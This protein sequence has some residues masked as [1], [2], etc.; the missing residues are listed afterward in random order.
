MTLIAGFWCDGA[1]VLCADSQ[2]TRGSL[3]NETNKLLIHGDDV[4][5]SL[6][7]GGAGSGE[8]TD[9]FKLRVAGALVGTQKSGEE[10]I[11]R[12]LEAQLVAFH[13]SDVYERFPGT[14]EEKTIVGLI[15]VRSALQEVFLYHYWTTVIKPVKTYE[16]AGEDYA[17]IKRMGERRFRAGMSVRQATLLGIELI[18][19]GKEISP[20]IGGQIRVVIARPE[21]FSVEDAA[22]V[23]WTEAEIATQ[24][25]VIDALRFELSSSNAQVDEQLRIFSNSITSIRNVYGVKYP[26]WPKPTLTDE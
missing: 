4:G 5:L 8:L 14:S 22:Q 26:M 12:E 6:V 2:E 7:V 19:E 13:R 3:K 25:Q 24:N 15:A 9:A 1:A 23:Q 10:H 16:L 18:S 20:Y 11:R 21:G 17:F